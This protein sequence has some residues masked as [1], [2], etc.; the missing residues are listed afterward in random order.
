MIKINALFSILCGLFF[1]I[2]TASAMMPNEEAL[3]DP[4]FVARYGCLTDHFLIKGYFEKE[5]WQEALTVVESLEKK[6]YSDRSLTVA[7]GKIFYKMGYYEKALENFQLALQEDYKCSFT[8]PENLKLLPSPEFA[9]QGRIWGYISQ[10]YKSMGNAD[11]ASSAYNTA[12]NFFR[13]SRGVPI[14]IPIEEKI[15]DEAA[16]KSFIEKSFI[17]IDLNSKPLHPFR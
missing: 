1:I 4:K 7:K 3:R 5:A 16:F 13:E 15:Q 17:I 11:K 6:G 2:R 9:D 8:Q 10:V 12:V 14:D